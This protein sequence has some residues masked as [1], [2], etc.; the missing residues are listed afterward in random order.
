MASLTFFQVVANSLLARKCF[1]K[2]PTLVTASNEL[3][4]R[5]LFKNLALVMLS[6]FFSFLLVE[7]MVTTILINHG[8]FS[9]A[10]SSLLLH[11]AVAADVPAASALGRKAN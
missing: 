3:G 5:K 10:S 2:N 1:L 11:A 7:C 9:P 6:S 4:T 8:E